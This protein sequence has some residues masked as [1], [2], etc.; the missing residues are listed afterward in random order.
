[1]ID[2]GQSQNYFYRLSQGLNL[3]VVTVSIIILTEKSKSC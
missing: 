2:S 3:G 1:M